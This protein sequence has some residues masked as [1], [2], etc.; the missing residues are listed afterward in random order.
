M[1]SLIIV[2]HPNPGSARSM[3]ASILAA[4]KKILA[5]KGNVTVRDLYAMKFNPVL[6]GA[7]FEK[8]QQGS[9]AD[10]VKVEQ[11]LI[12]KAGRLVFVNPVWWASTPAML[13]GYIDRVFSYGFAYAFEGGQIKGLLAGRK[14]VV[15]NTHGAPAEHYGPMREAMARSFED[16]TLR[17]CGIEVERHLWFG[18]ALNSDEA[19][20]TAAAAEVEKVLAAL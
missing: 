19:A 7:D 20:R 14:A 18:G 4:A 2:A 12:R 10:D 9:V 13:K 6:S 16:G 17:F 15:I 11:D 3:N 1:D 5:A 8:M